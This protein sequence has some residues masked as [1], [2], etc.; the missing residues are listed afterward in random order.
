MRN[1][2]EWPNRA[3]G[4]EFPSISE[5]RTLVVR[6]GRCL[7]YF[8]DE[9]GEEKRLN[10]THIHLWDLLLS[11]TNLRDWVAGQ[12]VSW[13]SNQLIGK[14]LGIDPGYVPRLLRGLEAVGACIR[15][16]THRNRRHGAGGIDMASTFFLLDEL[17]SHLDGIHEDLDD[18]RAGLD[19]RL[20]GYSSAFRWTLKT[21][22]AIDD[23]YQASHVQLLELIS[24]LKDK[25]FSALRPSLWKWALGHH[26]INAALAL[27][28][29][30]E[31]DG[32]HDRVKY[33]AGMLKKHPDDRSMNPAEGLCRAVV[34]TADRAKREG[35]FN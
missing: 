24:H 35:R 10:S 6:A 27:L 11:F 33:L 13:P 23:P 1:T 32:I 20:V 16:S 34:E 4:R 17:R 26:G 31:R 30:L 7:V 28:L 29:A 9:T 12:P 25:H 14:M 18:Y 21:H 3:E 22:F 2:T 19:A 15:E 8:D 5:I